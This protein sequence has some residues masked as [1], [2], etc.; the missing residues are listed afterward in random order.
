MVDRDLIE[1]SIRRMVDAESDGSLS[2]TEKV[3]AIDDIMSEDVTG[4]INGVA[5][6]DRSADRERELEFY[7]MVPDYQ[8]TL[9]TVVVDP[10]R[11]AFDWVFT[12]TNS[13]L[14]L[15]LEVRGCSIMEFGDDGKAIH[16]WVYLLDP[17][18]DAEAPA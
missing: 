15:D 13:A 1:T 10:P 14:G 8:R 16:Y 4:W 9:Q 3:A 5:Q 6:A 2:P 18:A 17:T 11:I 7:G 12:G